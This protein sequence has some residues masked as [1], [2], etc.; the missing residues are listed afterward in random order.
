[1]NKLKEGQ[2]IGVYQIIDNIVKDEMVYPIGSCH[3]G[4]PYEYSKNIQIYDLKDG[5]GYA[6]YPEEVQKVATL[7]VK[8]VK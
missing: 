1:M 3:L 7:I 8:K 4:R 2:R 5:N 6:Y